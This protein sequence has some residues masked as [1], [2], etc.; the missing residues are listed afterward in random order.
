MNRVNTS[1]E[2]GSIIYVWSNENAQKYSQNSSGITRQNYGCTPLYV[3]GYV[4]PVNGPLLSVA[5]ITDHALCMMLN[6][7]AALI[8]EFRCKYVG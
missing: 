1:L 3:T 4:L 7:T 8:L 5:A 6:V 2:T